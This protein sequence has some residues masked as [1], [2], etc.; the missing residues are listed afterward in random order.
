MLVTLQSSVQGVKV[1]SNLPRTQL[2]IRVLAPNSIRIGKYREEVETQ[3]GS[4]AFDGIEI[5]PADQFAPMVTWWA[6]D[7]WAIA[8]VPTAQ[9]IV[10]EASNPVSIHHSFSGR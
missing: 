4:G 10:I 6:G 1:K 8:V 5:N 2:I 3:Y 9:F 7:L